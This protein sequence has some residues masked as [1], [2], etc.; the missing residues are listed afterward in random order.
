MRTWVL[1]AP[2]APQTGGQPASEQT[3]VNANEGGAT[4]QDVKPPVQYGQS[5]P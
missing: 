2:V 4:G 1:R 5:A 3:K